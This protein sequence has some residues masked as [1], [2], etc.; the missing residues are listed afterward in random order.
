MP[1]DLTMI[2]KLFLF[3]PLGPAIILVGG[4]LILQFA[5][6]LAARRAAQAGLIPRV[7]GA[8]IFA[9]PQL[10]RLRLLVAL[11]TL[12]AAALLLFTF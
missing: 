5:R 1:D 9:E 7:P 3:Q 4:I 8:A 11:L 12:L 10:F 6:R 2:I